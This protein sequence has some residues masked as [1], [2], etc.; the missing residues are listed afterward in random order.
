MKR[1]SK[2]YQKFKEAKE[3]FKSEVVRSDTLDNYRLYVA[4][5]KTPAESY[6]FETSGTISNSTK[7]LQSFNR[8]VS[9]MNWIMSFAREIL[10]K[11]CPVGTERNLDEISEITMSVLRSCRRTETSMKPSFCDKTKSGQ[12]Y[13]QNGMDNFKRVFKTV[14]DMEGPMVKNIQNHFL[15]SEPLA[16]KYAAIVFFANNRFETSK[17]RLQYLTFYDFCYCADQ[18]IDNWT[19]G[20]AALCHFRFI[21]RMQTRPLDLKIK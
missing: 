14:E 5:E 19:I 2:R 4:M 13:I 21:E 11:N 1:P 8:T 20:K 3:N 6:P 7:P 17:K 18:M 16:Q 9:T 15:I 10:G 12:V